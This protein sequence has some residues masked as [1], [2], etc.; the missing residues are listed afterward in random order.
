ML[1]SD[2]FFTG[3]VGHSVCEDYALSGNYLV[4]MGE[5]KYHFGIVCDGCTQSPNTDVGARL[6]ALSTKNVLSAIFCHKTLAKDPVKTFE[7]IG[8]AIIQRAYSTLRSLELNTEAL[9]AALLIVVQS[10]HVS[11]EV[12]PKTYTIAFGDGFVYGVKGSDVVIKKISYKKEAPYYLRYSLTTSMKDQYIEQFGD[13][14]QIENWAFNLNEDTP[15]NQGP[16]L[17]PQDAFTPFVHVF[18][19]FDLVGVASDGFDQLR[20]ILE[21]GQRNPLTYEQV[22]REALNIKNFN[23]DFVSRHLGFL[24]K[25]RWKNRE[26][27]DDI[28]TA[29]IANIEE[30]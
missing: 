20:D 9:D 3:G 16:T 19:D 22:F 14:K 17:E 24:T 29:M 10:Q 2:H 28:S 11:G 12:N 4:G 5:F 6:L 18:E 25:R 7:T 26:L 13:Q 15:E 21:N 23:G 30:N 1:K 27:F 8:N